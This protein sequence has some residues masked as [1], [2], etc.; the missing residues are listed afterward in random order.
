MVCLYDKNG[1]EKDI[2]Q[3]KAE[4]WA[5]DLS[6]DFLRLHLRASKS[7]K[8]E[9]KAL[10]AEFHRRFPKEDLPRRMGSVR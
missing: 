4:V 9:R 1:K 8:F 2:R 3:Y 7:G 6:N 5:H 10:I